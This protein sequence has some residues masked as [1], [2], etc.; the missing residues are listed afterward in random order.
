[1]TCSFLLLL[2]IHLTFCQTISLVLLCF[3]ACLPSCFP[4][5]IETDDLATDDSG[6]DDE[7]EGA[8]DEKEFLESFQNHLRRKRQRRKVRK[9]PEVSKMLVHLAYWPELISSLIYF[10]VLAASV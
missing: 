2:S 6:D 8:V 4:R 3:N 7:V 1:M 10:K 5:F 9:A